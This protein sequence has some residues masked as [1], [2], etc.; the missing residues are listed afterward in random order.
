MQDISLAEDLPEIRDSIEFCENMVDTLQSELTGLKSKITRF[1]YLFT[2]V[3]KNVR[4][5]E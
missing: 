3:I 5:V 4:L 1:K 2:V